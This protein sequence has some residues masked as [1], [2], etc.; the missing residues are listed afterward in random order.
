MG[1]LAWLLTEIAQVC[2]WLWG[3]IVDLAGL[4]FAGLNALLNPILSP[5]F[6]MVNPVCTWLGDGVYAVLAPFPVWVGLVLLSAIAGVLLLVAFG[7]LSNQKAIGRAKDDIKANL[8]ALKLFKDEIR[9]TIW[10]QWRL[11]CAIGRLQR[12]MLLPVLILAIPMVPALAQMGIRYQWRP[13]QVGEQS[14]VVLKLAKAHAKGAK[15]KMEAPRGFVVEASVPGG[16]EVAWRI[17]ATEPGSH[18]LSFRVNDETMTK[19]LVVGESLE[20]VSALRPAGAWTSQALHPV[21]A[22]LTTS[23]AVESIEIR[24]PPRDSL[25]YG[26]D[27]WVLT[28]FV[29]SMVFAIVFRPVFNVRF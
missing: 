8:L 13:L 11:L 9:V 12:Y 3:V 1:F 14:V 21:E 20:R 26:A 28:F 25:I 17:R 2:T 10:A 27:Y 18:T 23:R 5:F 24:Y 19:E 22:P 16:G 29:V 6:R 7:R 4:A 15:V